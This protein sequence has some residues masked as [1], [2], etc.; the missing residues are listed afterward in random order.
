MDDKNLM[1]YVPKWLKVP[2]ISTFNGNESLLV[3]SEEKPNTMQQFKIKVETK[4]DIADNIELLSEYFENNT[5]T[6]KEL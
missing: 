6:L 2:V 3:Y 1:S 4:K 5:E